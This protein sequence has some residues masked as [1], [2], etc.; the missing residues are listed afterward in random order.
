[1]D[2]R[3]RELAGEGG[4]GEEQLAEQP[5]ARRVAQ[6][7]GKDALH[8]HLAVAER[9]LAQKHFRG[10]PLAQLADDGVIADLLHQR[11]RCARRLRARAAAFRTWAGAVPP[12]WSRAATEPSTVRTR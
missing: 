10:R 3:V 11:A 8:R 7:L 6:R 4:F 9:V 1:A 5:P 12:M 2:V